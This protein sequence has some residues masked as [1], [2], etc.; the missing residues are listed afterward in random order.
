MPT[1]NDMPAWDSRV[2]VLQSEFSISIEVNFEQFNER[3][4]MAL[5]GGPLAW[6][7]YEMGELYQPL[8]FLT[9][10]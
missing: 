9:S 1:P 5:L 8:W 6:L 10:D 4:S 3:L 7:W 2:A